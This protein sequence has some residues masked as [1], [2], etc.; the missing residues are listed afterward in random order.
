MGLAAPGSLNAAVERASAVLG[1]NPAEAGRQADAILR[2]APKD[3]RA[4]LILA[5]SRRR[6]GDA[7]GAMAILGPL[8]KAY[9]RAAHTHYELGAALAARGR[10]AEAIPALRHAVT[11]N[12]DLAE[13]WRALGDLLFA[14]GDSAGSERAF[15][16]HHRATIRDPALR[17][18]A[19]ALF[20]GRI[21]EAEQRLRAHLAARP[22]DPA[23]LR[24]MAEARARQEGFVDAETLLAEALRLD[25]G[26]DG[27]RFSYATA[28]FRQ[29]KAA[30][31]LVEVER[32][33]AIDPGE[34]AYRN[35]LAACLALTGDFDR[36][37]EAYEGLLAQFPR[38]ARIWLN[39]GHALRAVGR[40]EAA[41]KAY[42]RAIAL[43]PGLGD[44][45]WS[46]AN[47]KVDPLTR[48]DEAAIEG[49]LARAD[50][51][52][53]D[54]LHLRYALA[55][56]REDRGDYAGAFEQYAAGA[57]LR[58]RSLN[59]DPDEQTIL[60]RRS[61][62]LFTPTFFSA[63]EGPDHQPPTRSSSSVCPGRVRP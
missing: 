48:Q 7:A 16:E 34:A 49:Q 36:A 32:L 39:H 5:S 17:P 53:D 27:A 52:P 25:P 28:L 1:A 46:L 44:A 30:E 50:L 21:A 24:L 23:A 63:R 8:A 33:M 35:L 62:A 51:D 55:K 58:R 42:R 40:R 31:A 38:Q 56:A 11:L 29:Q 10:P 61:T 59:F 22:A 18:V 9:P 60:V 47:L 4:L 37:M 20:A 26:H 14:A 45:Y 54:R 3:P 43:A 41:R 2:V 15:A 6:L 13:A 57:E 19:E 12:R